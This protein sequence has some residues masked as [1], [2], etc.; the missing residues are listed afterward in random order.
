MP[1]AIEMLREDHRKVQQLFQEFE[2]SEDA[3]S[4]RQIA[5]T[6]IQELELH[7]TLEEEI[8]YPAAME[9]LEDPDLINEAQEEHHVVRDY[10]RTNSKRCGVMKS[11]LR[12]SLR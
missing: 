6:A 8:F 3:A 4:K 10:W 12:P 2:Q 11:A 5:Q 7:A 9:E 1:D